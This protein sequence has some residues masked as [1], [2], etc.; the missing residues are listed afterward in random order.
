MKKQSR[1]KQP[2]FR[3][4]IVAVEERSDSASGA[5]SCAA[6]GN[7]TDVARPQWCRIHVRR[8]AE[9]VPRG[10]LTLNSLSASPLLRHLTRI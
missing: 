9:S 5:A 10:G 8:G 2:S 1:R 4:S 6:I 7:E 3:K